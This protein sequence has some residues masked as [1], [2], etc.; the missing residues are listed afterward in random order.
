MNRHSTTLCLAVAALAAAA[1]SSKQTTAPVVDRFDS[2]VLIRSTPAPNGLAYLNDPVALDFSVPVDFDTASF[3]TV[4]FQALDDQGQPLAEA[5][6]GRF[7][8][9][10][11]P[12]D[13]DT[14]RRLQFEPALPRANDYLDGGLRPGRTYLVQLIGGDRIQG[15]ALRSQAGRA[16]AVPTSFRFATVQG[17][18]PAQLF[19]NP[20][21]G[22]PRRLPVDGLVVRRTAGAETVPLGLFGAPPLEIRLRFDQALDP[23]DGNVPVHFD[24]DPTKRHIADRGRIFLEY[25][26]PERGASTWIPAGVELEQ[27]DADGATVVLRPAGVLPNNADIRVIVEPTLADIA[28]ESNVGVLSFDRVF[29]TFRTEAAYGQQWNGIVESFVDAA[30][31]DREAVFAEPIAEVGPG[32][33]KAAFDFEGAETTTDYA[34]MSAETV[35]DTSFTQVV[36]ANG[37]PQ[38]VSGGVFRFRNVTIPQGAVVRGTGPNP[39]VFVCTGDVRVHGE[40][41]VRGGDGQRTNTLNSANYPQGGGI[42]GPRGGNGGNGSPSSSNRS[43]TGA[44]GNGPRQVPGLG[45]R[46]GQLACSAICS[47]GNGGGS[48]GGGGTLATQGDPWYRAPAVGPNQ[49]AQR[50]GRGGDGCSGSSGGRTAVLAGGAAADRVFVDSRADNDH[51]GAAVDLGRHLRI[52][53][54]LTVPVG[55]GG[56]GGGGDESFNQGCGP[57]QSFA[58]DASGGGGGGGGGVLIVKALGEIEITSTGRITAD[59]GHGG[60]GAQAGSCNRAGGGGGGA[61]GMVILMSA[62]R[63]VLHAHGSA[64]RWLYSQNDYDFCISADGGVCKTGTFTGPQ[65]TGKYPASGQPV[66]TGTAYD[67]NPLGGFGGLGIVQLMAPVGLDNQDQTNTRLDDSIDVYRN[68]VLQTGAAKQA[69]LAWR[70]F[71]DAS[72]TWRDDNGNLVNIGADEGDIRPAPRLLPVPFGPRSRV[73]SKWIDTGCSQRRELAIADGLPRGIVTAGGAM[74]GPVYEFAGLDTAAATPGYAAFDITGVRATVAAPLVVPAVAITTVQ[75][76]AMR[77]GRTVHVVIAAT[78]AFGDAADRFVQHEA[79]LLD[80]TGTVLASLRI[81]GND[82]TTLWL[83]A[84]D[85]LLPEAPVLVRIRARFFRV[86]TSGSQGLGPVAA[87]GTAPRANVRIGFAFHTDPGSA[88]GVRYPATDGEFVYDLASQDLA[89]WT[90]L[91]G[92][93]RYVQWDV[94]FDSAFAPGEFVGPASPRPAL[95]EL[96]LP[97]RF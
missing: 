94:L 85:G 38:N 81:V 59:G 10:R 25:D 57:D 1:C 52:Q 96:R 61:G 45:G 21:A 82:A 77:D 72:G 79:E 91:H 41:S 84:G 31:I 78:P 70:G 20:K 46:G 76:N 24:V 42:G 65:V 60:G 5:V 44:T 86:E 13:I 64:S 93:P 28:G 74:A 49:F 88:T 9:A 97:F 40:L 55:G 3:D 95:T 30:G 71:P 8:L 48:G 6:S 18:S 29:G 73:R 39:M 7:R 68:G 62:R 23:H 51:F 43:P 35:L 33:V 19:R 67:D 11:S 32:Y 92:A 22:G 56:G 17:T 75:A 37:L 63:I 4:A 80:A 54:E 26:D 83:D 50:S 87:S 58:N 2:L 47:Q 16:L 12:G 14:G 53:G 90:A 36:P 89:A 66:M 15:T 27:N 69:I 34:P